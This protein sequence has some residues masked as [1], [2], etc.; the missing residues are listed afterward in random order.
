[1]VG[2]T[3]ASPL[4]GALRGDS[5]QELD[6]ERRRRTLHASS[7]RPIHRNSTK[8]GGDL[9]GRVASHGEPRLLAPRQLDRMKAV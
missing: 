5:L 1:M 7:K 6:D 4:L 2:R 8:T 3:H 9:P